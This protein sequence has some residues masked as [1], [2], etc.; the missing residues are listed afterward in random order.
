MSGK[1]K[2]RPIVNEISRHEI[3]EEDIVAN[4][5]L[6]KYIKKDIPR[7]ERILKCYETT[8]KE[9]F[10][11]LFS[12]VEKMLKRS[13]KVSDYHILY[14][15]CMAGVTA[16][17]IGGYYSLEYGAESDNEL[18]DITLGSYY[19]G[20]KILD[21]LFDE[22][23]EGIEKQSKDIK[24]ICVKLAS[25][26]SITSMNNGILNELR[27]EK[28]I[29]PEL[30]NLTKLTKGDTP[31]L[32]KWK[33]GKYKCGSLS[34]FIKAYAKIADNLTLSLI[35]DYLI[36]EKTGKQYTKSTIETELK[37][38]GPGRKLTGI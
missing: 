20:K 8:A 16:S 3:T 17:I 1:K 28:E 2:D 29:I 6:K 30:E 33:N 35:Q 38:H 7:V 9:R 18:Y 31:E 5:W 10:R 15:Y 4:P 13:A 34:V 23:T 21:E 24:D 12:N 19:I 37:I 25:I 32:R 27:N 14:K 26:E 36:S 11:G 22:F